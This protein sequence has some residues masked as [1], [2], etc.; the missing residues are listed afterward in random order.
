MKLWPFL[1]S[2]LANWHVWTSNQAWIDLD[3][4]KLVIVHGPTDPTIIF[5][6][7]GA[8]SGVSKTANLENVY[9][10]T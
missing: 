9:F 3:C 6:A 4:L 7:E 5:F 10:Q 8:S 2:T 1:I